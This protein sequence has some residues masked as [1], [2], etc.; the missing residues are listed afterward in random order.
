MYMFFSALQFIVNIRRKGQTVYQQVLSPLRPDGGRLDSWNWA[1]DPAHAHYH[2]LYPR[3]WTRYELPGQNVTLICRQ[4]SPVFPHDYKVSCEIDDDDCWCFNVLFKN[5]S[6]ISAQ[7]TCFLTLL[8]MIESMGMRMTEPGC[9]SR[10]ESNPGRQMSSTLSPE[11]T[12]HLLCNSCDAQITNG[13][14]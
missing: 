9:S 12:G 7:T 4:I 5:S 6:L 1:F 3:A 10:E 8:S 14:T 2:G 13:F 11:L